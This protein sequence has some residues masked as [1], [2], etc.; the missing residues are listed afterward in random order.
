[1]FLL[2][3]CFSST[4]DVVSCPSDTI[5]GS[6]S[7]SKDDARLDGSGTKNAIEFIVVAQALAVVDQ[8]HC[9]SYGGSTAAT[10]TVTAKAKATAT[11]AAIAA[12]PTPPPP[13]SNDVLQVKRGADV[14]AGNHPTRRLPS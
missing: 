1:M 9:E 3:I 14:A 12:P 10:A 2:F 7:V 8:Q 13:V 6:V 4:D 5:G 11:I